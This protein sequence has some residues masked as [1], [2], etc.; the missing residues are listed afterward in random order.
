MVKIVTISN[1]IAAE[2]F[3]PEHGLSILIIKGKNKILLDTG[4]GIEFFENS[5]KLNINF[6]DI[7]SMVL[8]HGHYDHC[9]NIHRI[10]DIN[11]NINV[12]YHPEL[13][14]ERYSIHPD[15]DPSVKYI[16][17]S[18]DNILA[19]KKSSGIKGNKPTQ[20]AENVYITGE[21]PRVSGEDCGGPFFFDRD[22]INPDPI[23]DDQALW[24]ETEKGLLIITGCCHSG[25]INT[26]EHI[27]KLSG[28]K[29]IYGIIGGFHLL[30]ADE[31]RITETIKYL[32][33]IKPHFLQPGHCTGDS[34]IE[35]LKENL[36]CRIVTLESGTEVSY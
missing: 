11:N 33:S 7:N 30:K 23:V 14:R 18:E 24:I 27:I 32:K 8:S 19:L 6:N 25:I 4:S 26:V 29:K 17:V 5:K 31:K 10:L 34:V 15:R 36:D 3:K 16:G 12:Y 13:T 9:G 21:I 1:N 22:G 28:I 35:R 2:G 20:I